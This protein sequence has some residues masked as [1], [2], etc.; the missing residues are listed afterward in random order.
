MTRNAPKLRAK[1]SMRWRPTCGCMTC[2]SRSDFPPGPCGHGHSVVR[3]GFDGVR[4]GGACAL[5]PPDRA[6]KDTL[7]RHRG[8]VA[9]PGGRPAM[10]EFLPSGRLLLSP[11][12]RSDLR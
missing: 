9:V 10:I 7:L 11:A 2:R 12:E 4:V 1:L 3:G 6:V 5:Q 8:W